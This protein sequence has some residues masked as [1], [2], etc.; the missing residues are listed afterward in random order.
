M[1]RTD[2]SIVLG[3]GRLRELFDA[4]V[5]AGGRGA[6]CRRLMRDMG[7]GRKHAHR[8]QTMVGKGR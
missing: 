5:A 3:T 1:T 4:I 2:S 7:Q 8:S 6:T